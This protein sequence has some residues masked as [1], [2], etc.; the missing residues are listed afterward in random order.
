MWES[1]CVSSPKDDSTARHRSDDEDE[2]ETTDEDSDEEMRV[3]DRLARLHTVLHAPSCSGFLMGLP[4]YRNYPGHT[5][6]LAVWVVSDNP[7]S[8]G[9]TPSYQP[10]HVS[11]STRPSCWA[12][13]NSGNSGRS[14]V[15]SSH[16]PPV[17][18]V[19]PG[20]SCVVCCDRRSFRSRGVFH[21]T[22]R[23]SRG[24]SLS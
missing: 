3:I 22:R 19:Q 23:V 21:S 18:H 20:V 24:Y 8:H 1:V 10:P 7:A 9:T 6:D 17:F 15:L 5:T 12:Q 16:L 4:S 13:R 14:G 11:P 2:A